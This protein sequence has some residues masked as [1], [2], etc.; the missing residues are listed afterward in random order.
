MIRPASLQE[1]GDCKD[2]GDPGLPCH[3]PSPGSFL[4][5]VDRGL[6]VLPKDS[7]STTTWMFQH[8]AGLRTSLPTCSAGLIL[9][10]NTNQA[11]VRPQGAHPLSPSSSFQPEMLAPTC[12]VVYPTT[13]TTVAQ[14]GTED[15]PRS[16]T[17]PEQLGCPHSRERVFSVSLL[18]WRPHSGP[19]SCRGQSHMCLSN[20]GCGPWQW[21]EPG[22]TCTPYL[23]FLCPSLPL[24]W[25]RGGQ[26]PG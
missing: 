25:T 21:Q 4:G 6:K 23:P 20:S 15:T 16:S 22:A 14:L 17:C 3:L 2:R 13:P 26:G 19:H 7:S 11:C 10:T 12:P 9:K 18:R 8:G 24:L 1:G 5:L